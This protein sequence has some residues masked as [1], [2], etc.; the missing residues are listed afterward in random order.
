MSIMEMWKSNALRTAVLVVLNMAL[1]SLGTLPW[2]VLGLLL[3]LIGMFLAYRQGTYFGHEACA[4]LDNVRRVEA[5]SDH[6][7]EQFDKKVLSRTWSVGRGIAG[8]LAAALIPYL[9]GCVYLAAVMLDISAVQ[10]PARLVALVLAMPFLPILASWFDSFVEIHP[11]I[12]TLLLVSPFVLPLSIFAGYMQG[13]RLWARSE[14]AMAE[15]RRRARA[16]SRVAKK[17]PPKVA[18]PEI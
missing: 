16:K 4:L 17:R 14:K 1:I 12:V 7:G 6:P 2:V 15:G 8:V 13:P 5:N 3:L 11:A 9:A 10:M 18:K